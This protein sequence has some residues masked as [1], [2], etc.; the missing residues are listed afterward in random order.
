MKSISTF[1]RRPPVGG[2]S[3][4]MTVFGSPDKL[5]A[6]E[7]PSLAGMTTAAQAPEIFH[8]PGTPLGHRDDVVNLQVGSLSAHLAGEPVPG[9]HLSPDGGPVGR[10]CLVPGRDVLPGLPKLMLSASAIPEGLGDATLG[11][12]DRSCSWHSWAPPRSL[13]P[14]LDT[15]LAAGAQHLP[16]SL[17]TWNHRAKASTRLGLLIN[18]EI[19]QEGNLGNNNVSQF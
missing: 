6:I 19:E 11:Q 17:Q 5:T 4:S 1:P 12:A 8:L 13:W 7:P 2:S 18:R 14:R 10:P 9:Q 15:E 16:G 3:S